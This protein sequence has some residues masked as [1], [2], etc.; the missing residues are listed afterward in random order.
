MGT[1]MQGVTPYQSGQ[2]SNEHEGSTRIPVH[3]RVSQ[4]R[5][6]GSPD[7][8]AQVLTAPPREFDDTEHFLHKGVPEARGAKYRPFWE[9]LRGRAGIS[10]S[11]AT[12]MGSHSS[13]PG[14]NSLGSPSNRHGEK[15]GYPPFRPAGGGRKP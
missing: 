14:G 7:P 8:L 15:S 9:P 1:R 4:R 2:R 5:N 3:F 12:G 13:R 10:G 6:A 11:R